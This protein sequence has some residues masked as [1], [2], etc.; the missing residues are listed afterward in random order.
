[1]ERA[2]TRAGRHVVGTTLD[3]L[4]GALF[5]G[6]DVR[7][8]SILLRRSPGA[9]NDGY[10]L[11]K[12]PRILAIAA[13]DR[14]SVSRLRGR[15]RASAGARLGH[16]RARMSPPGPVP[17]SPI[18]PPRVS[19]FFRSTSIV[20]ANTLLSRVTGLLRDMVYSRMFGAG[21]AHG[22][23]P[24]RVQDPE[25]HAP[26][27]RRGRV[28]AGLR[29]GR[30]RVQ[31]AQREHDEVRELVDGAAGTLAWFLSVVTII[32]VD[33]G[34]A[35]RAA[36]RARAFAPRRPRS[37][38]PSRCCAGRSR[39]CSSSRSR[40]S[41]AA[42]STATASSPCRRFTSTLL[43]LVMIVFAAWIAPHFE[44]PAS[45][46]RSACSSRASRSSRSRCRSCFGSGCC[47]GRAGAGSTTAC[48]RS[49]G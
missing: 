39:T 13:S 11:Q 28:L 21:A 49:G 18:E 38:S 35:A 7:H 34:A 42:C 26:A 25:L 22:R 4:L 19:G 9:A 45:C 37:T 40:R 44:R 12:E 32:G 15:V 20:G 8:G 24:G 33:R 36:V 1:M 16:V 29:A 2:Q 31:G 6:L 43:N 3:G 14:S 46:S 30:L 27:V 23:V 5:S 47:A 41:P 10:R 17:P 48:A